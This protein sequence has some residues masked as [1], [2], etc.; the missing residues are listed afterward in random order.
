[1][2][3]LAR[4]GRR[5]LRDCPYSDG[6]DG[7]ANWTARNEGPLYGHSGRNTNAARPKVD[8]L[9]AVLVVSLELSANTLQEVVEAVWRDNI[10]RLCRHQ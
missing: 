2:I 8:G 1:M 10:C 3:E 6:R 5:N 7:G 9:L 4:G